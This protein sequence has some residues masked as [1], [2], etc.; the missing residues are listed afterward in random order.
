MQE[1]QD[2]GKK[3]LGIEEA[4]SIEGYISQGGQM[5][6][7]LTAPFM[8]SHQEDSATIEFPNSLHVDFFADSSLTVESQLFAKY[9]RYNQNIGRVYL[10]DSVIAF[11]IKG[12]TMRSDDLYWDQAKGIFYTDT[13]VRIRTATEKLD[14]SGLVADQNFSWWTLKQ[15][16]GPMLIPDSSLPAD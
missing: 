6:A 7:K 8:V 5:K 10:R 16:T 9:G 13:H 2:L 11:N 3:K 4:R 12:D 14:G 1:V 15:A